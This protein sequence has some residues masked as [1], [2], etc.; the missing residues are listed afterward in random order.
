M[1]SSTHAEQRSITKLRAAENAR[2]VSD[3][4]RGWAVKIRAAEKGLAEARRVYGLLDKEDVPA[5]IQA[6]QKVLVLTVRRQV[7]IECWEEAAGSVWSPKGR[8][9]Q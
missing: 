3:L 2:K 7:L 1:T 8:H 6:R 9:G 4:L 5:L